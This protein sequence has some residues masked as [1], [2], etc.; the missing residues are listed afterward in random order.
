MPRKLIAILGP[1]ASGKTDLALAIASAL[2]GEVIC[3]DSRQF[4]RRMDVGTAKPTAAERAAVP[5]HLFD[6]A[7][8]GET[9]GLGRFLDLARDACEE[10]WARG[11]LPLL[12]GGTGQYARAFL[13]GW[14]VPAVAPD[15]AFRAAL[16]ARAAAE[17]GAALHAELAA[18]DPRAAARIDPRNTRRTIRALEVVQATARPFSEHGKRAVDF[19]WLAL[20]LRWPRE[21]LYARIDARVEAM[22][23][24]GLLEEAAALGDLLERTPAATAIGYREARACLAGEISLDEAKARTKFATHRLARSQGAWF[25]RDDARIEWLEPAGAVPAALAICQKFLRME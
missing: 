16:E 15:A 11:H 13:E 8:P 14:D 2:S 9:V 7:E 24:G 6:I 17:G 20:A 10:T 18:V 22:F 21:E 5:H 19:E 1:T 4:Y 12:V 23:A 25:R 3:A